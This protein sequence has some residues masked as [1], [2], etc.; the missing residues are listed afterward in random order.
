MV[1]R[2]KM[3][4]L[5]AGSSNRRISSEK[6]H[7]SEKKQYTDR[8]I[9]FESLLQLASCSSDSNGMAQSVAQLYFDSGMKF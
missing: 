9:P 1:T 5:K 8:A 7:L 3:L 2:A 6:K 4:L